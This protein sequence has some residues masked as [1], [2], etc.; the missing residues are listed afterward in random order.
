MVPSPLGVALG[1]GV[2]DVVRS[3]PRLRATAAPLGGQL[4]LTVHAAAGDLAVPM[5]SL[6]TRA[7]RV[8]GFPVLLDLATASNLGVLVMPAQF[9]ASVALAVPNMATLRGIVLEGSAA[10]LTVAG[11]VDVTNP[12]AVILH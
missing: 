9:E 4:E 8:L 12:A 10:I 7:Q 1:T 5:L 11:T 2:A 3:V 6:G